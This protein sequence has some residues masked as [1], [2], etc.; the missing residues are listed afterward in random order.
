MAQ[1]GFHF[2]SVPEMAIDTSIGSRIGGLDHQGWYPL[3]N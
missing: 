3:V 1:Y 2:F